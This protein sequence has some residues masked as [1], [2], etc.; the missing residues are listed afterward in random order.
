[1][2]RDLYEL[3]SIKSFQLNGESLQAVIEDDMLSGWLV[4]DYRANDINKFGL[5]IESE[6]QLT[7]ESF[8]KVDGKGLEL[9]TTRALKTIEAMVGREI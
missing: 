2:K 6:R 1:M 3:H 8:E 9:L 5:E 7:N 4:S